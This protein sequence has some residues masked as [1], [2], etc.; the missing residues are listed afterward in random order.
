MNDVTL[1]SEVKSAAVAG[2]LVMEVTGTGR[3]EQ[4]IRRMA[5]PHAAELNKMPEWSARTKEIRG[6][7]G[8]QLSPSSSCCLHQ[9]M[10]PMEAS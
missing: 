3:T 2:G 4:A 6:K 1:R 7:L 9:S 8:L 5:V 10:F